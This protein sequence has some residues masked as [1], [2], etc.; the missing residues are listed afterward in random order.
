MNSLQLDSTER[1]FY[2]AALVTLD[3]PFLIADNKWPTQSLLIH[4]IEW[5]LRQLALVQ[6]YRLF[7]EILKPIDDL[8]SRWYSVFHSLSHRKCSACY[9]LCSGVECFN[10]LSE[11]CDVSYFKSSHVYHM[12]TLCSTSQI[13]SHTF[14]S[15]TIHCNTITSPYL[16]TEHSWRATLKWKDAKQKWTKCD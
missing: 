9:L 3:T 14:S 11:N 6:W 13:H 15:P 8:V 1:H 10:K 16:H 7:P 5:S 2:Y 4:V 12:N